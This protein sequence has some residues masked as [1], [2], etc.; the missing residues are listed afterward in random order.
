[1]NETFQM[2]I[3]AVIVTHNRCTLLS[4]CIDHLQI[5][6]R[7]VQKIL[8]VNNASTDGTVD[9]LEHRKI[10][11]LTQENVGSAGG[12]H[13]GIQHALEQGF[14]AVWLMDDDGFP[15]S[16]ALATLSSRLTLDVAAVSAVV[17]REDDPAR[18]V[19]PFPL[20]DEAGMPV[21][22]GSPRKLNTLAELTAIATNGTYPFAHFF[23]G[24]LISLDAV[25]KIGNVNRDFFIFGDEV[26]YFF[27]LRRA[28]AV[29]SV[30]DALHYHPD[31]SQRPYS[32]SKV[33]FYLKNT[34][35]LNSRYFNAIWLRHL[36][37][38]IAVLSRTATRNGVL[39]AL[40]YVCGT[41]SPMF[42]VAIV[43]GLQ[44]KVGKDFNG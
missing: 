11:Y 19:F 1:M 29:L 7:Q 9:M 42:Y 36:M 17:V 25:R 37:A 14:D 44:G 2:N 43:R 21:L 8:V 30:I 31:V 26:D 4:R 24:T 5:Q 39:T 32:P 12:W 28:G 16:T 15:D 33:Y 23:N 38:V 10:P 27:R 35:I 3:L 22:M 41:K 6:I 34:L 13:S 40:S 20:L 18:F